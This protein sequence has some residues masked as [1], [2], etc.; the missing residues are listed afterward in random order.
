[1]FYVCFRYGISRRRKTKDDR[2]LPN[3]QEEVIQ[4]FHADSAGL[5]VLQPEFILNIDET[6]ALFDAIPNYTLDDRGNRQ[7][8]ITS[9]RGNP[10]LGCTVTLGITSDGRKME[11][12]ITFKN[13]TRVAMAEIEANPPQNV[14][15]SGHPCCP[16][17]SRKYREHSVGGGGS[18]T[19]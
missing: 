1:M 12:H 3:N 4:T 10:R 11:A 13:P 9:S 8:N 5:M 19:L 18:C 17:I 16:S 14:H 15:V 7:V 2:Q 6:F